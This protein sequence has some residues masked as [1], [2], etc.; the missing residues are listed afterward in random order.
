MT[1]DL[2]FSSFTLQCHSKTE[3]SETFQENHTESESESAMRQ[4]TE[5]VSN[6]DES[7]FEVP[8]TLVD[9]P[10]HMSLIKT[11]IGGKICFLFFDSFMYNLI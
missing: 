3:S 4:S 9:C 10:G 7:P 8:I 5:F 6:R 11:A 2:G 1:L